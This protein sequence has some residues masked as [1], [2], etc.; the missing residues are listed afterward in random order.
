[1]KKVLKIKQILELRGLKQKWLADKIGVTEVTISNWVN[2]RTYPS[3]ETLISISTVL[4]IEVKE[5]FE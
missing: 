3:I 2:N 1:M 5:L 4:K